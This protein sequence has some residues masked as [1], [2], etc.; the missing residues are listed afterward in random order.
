MEQELQ[1]N[2][3][4]ITGLMQQLHAIAAKQAIAEQP[5]TAPTP[6]HMMAREQFHTAGG[7]P[8]SVGSAGTYKSGSGNRADCSPAEV[9]SKTPSAFTS[10]KQMLGQEQMVSYTET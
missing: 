6:G 3:L 9:T 1:A 8:C 2:K 10:G 7:S 5:T 4:H